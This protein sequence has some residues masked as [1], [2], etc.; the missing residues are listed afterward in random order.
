MVPVG[1]VLS[2][3]LVSAQTKFTLPYSIRVADRII[4][5]AHERATETLTVGQILSHSSNVGAVTLA[6]LLGPQRLAKWIT[7]F[8]F[9]RRTGV[10]FPG[11]SPGIVL[12]VERWYGSTMGTVPIGQGIAV[13]PIQ[14]A[15]AY[16]AVANHGVWLTP[17]LVDHV[18][19]GGRQKVGHRRILSVRVA[20][21][22]LSMLVNVVAEGTGTLAA[23]PGYLVA[24]KTGTAAKPDSLGGYSSRYVASFVGIVPAS[25][26]RL[27]ILVAVDEPQGA[28]WGGVVAAPAFQQI[29]KFDLQYLEVP[30]DSPSSLE[31]ALASGSR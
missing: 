9:G 10:D 3:K 20:D 29:A 12:P 15:A 23:V 28:I 27:V 5:D 25:K 21:Q 24:G 2:E 22:L 13:T 18:T 14:M 19:G 8:G 11:E 31:R 4:H 30:P 7:R 26:P 17:H 6:R 1:G 16:A